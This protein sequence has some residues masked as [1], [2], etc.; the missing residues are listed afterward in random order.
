MNSNKKAARAVGLLFLLKVL[1]YCFPLAA[2]GCFLLAQPLMAVEGIKGNLVDVDWLEKNLKNADVLILDASP[3]QIYT[4]QHIPGAVNVDLFTYGLQ[5]MAVADME[6]LYRSWG[7]SSGKK[8][9]MYD[10]GG[11]MLATKQF[12]SLITTA[13]PQR[14]F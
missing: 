12:F 9:V 7:I 5:E 11:A 3:A 6:Q 13:F 4:A 2:A 10:Q 8:I 1:K 14:T